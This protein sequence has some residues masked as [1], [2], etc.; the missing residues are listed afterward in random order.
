MDENAISISVSDEEREFIDSQI[1][2]G[3]YADDKELLHAGIAALERE[4]RLQELRAR[5]AAS[6]AQYARGEYK[7]FNE[8]DDL[9]QYIIDNAEALRR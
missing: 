7:S 4:E 6:D 1:A 9:A 8:S 5:I 3:R 2:A